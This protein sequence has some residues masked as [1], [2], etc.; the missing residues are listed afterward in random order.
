MKIHLPPPPPPKDS[1]WRLFKLLPKADIAT[2]TD[3][4]RKRGQYRRAVDNIALARELGEE[5][6]E[7]WEY[8]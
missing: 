2:A 6:L 5:L 1:E 8:D 7:V 4:Q 3:E